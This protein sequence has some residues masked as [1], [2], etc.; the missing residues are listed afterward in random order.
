MTKLEWTIEKA[1]GDVFDIAREDV[2][3][4]FT[5]KPF[6]NAVLN[7]TLNFRVTIQVC[8]GDTLLSQSSRNS[9]LTLG[10]LLDAF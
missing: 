9:E 5:V 8:D 10:E 7:K 6:K 2:M 3:K 1:L 4:N